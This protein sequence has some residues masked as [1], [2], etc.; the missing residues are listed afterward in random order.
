MM[1]MMTTTIC[2]CCSLIVV[3]AHHGHHVVHIG[4][5][6]RVGVGVGT[7]RHGGCCVSCFAVNR[8]GQTTSNAAVGI[9]V[10]VIMMMMINLPNIPLLG[11]RSAFQQRVLLLEMVLV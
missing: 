6:F 5:E 3:I 4:I 1:M 9:V 11:R 7:H 8:H 10:V 2:C